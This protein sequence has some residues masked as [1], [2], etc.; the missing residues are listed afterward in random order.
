M[1]ENSNPTQCQ[2]VLDY[3]SDFGSITQYE[4]IRDIGV[5]RLASRVSELKKRGYPI[6]SSM[7]AVVNKYGE[8]C[9]VKRYTI[10]KEVN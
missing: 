6:R 7:V 9:H 4:A 3:I 2:R 5:M 8:K 10:E 1:S